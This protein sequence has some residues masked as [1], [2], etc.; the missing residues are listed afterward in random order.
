MTV[1]REYASL[2]SVR[3]FTQ[4]LE[5]VGCDH[6]EKFEVKD[7]ERYCNA[8]PHAHE[9]GLRFYSGFWR[10][11][12]QDLALL[13]AAMSRGKV[14][15]VFLFRYSS[16]DWVNTRYALQTF[17]SCRLLM[18]RGRSATRSRRTSL[19]AMPGKVPLAAAPG[20]P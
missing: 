2:E 16:C 8:S 18:R 5:E 11:G 17:W 19:L 13:R 7:A 6:L 3:A 9:A 1:G 10:L 4:V 20:T 14:P 15:F 12:G